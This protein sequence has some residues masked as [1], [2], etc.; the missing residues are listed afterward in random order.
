V[1][2]ATPGGNP[3]TVTFARL[4]TRSVARTAVRTRGARPPTAPL[5]RAPV[6]PR[7]P[8]P[9]E[10]TV[11]VEAPQAAPAPP[12]VAGRRRSSTPLLVVSAV[13]ASVQMSWS[14]VVPVL[15][16]YAGR[17]GLGPAELGLVVSVFGVGRLLVNVPAG[18]L[19]RRVDRRW[20]M[21]G[22]TAAVVVFQSLTGLVNGFGPLLVARLCTGLA[23]GVAITSGMTLL[24]D[25]ATP[26]NRG[27]DMA[28]LQGLQL[29]GGALGP[30]LGGFLAVAAGPRAAFLLSG[31]V[32]TGVLLWG[33]Q[34]LRRTPVPAPPRTG[35]AESRAGWLSRDLCG[36][37]LMGFAVFFHRFG[38]LQS[39]VPLI[40]YEQAGI[41][42]G[43]LGLLL[44]AVTLCNVLMVRFA[45]GLSDRVGRK[46]VIIPSSVCVVVGSAGLALGGWSVGFVVATLVTGVAAGFSGPTPAAYLVDVALPSA[47][48]VV[49][50]IYR[51]FGDLGG[52]VGPLLLGLLAETLGFGWAAISLAGVVAVM[53][54]AFGLLSREST[55]PHRVAGVVP[56]DAA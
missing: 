3:H 5:A 53:T 34:V 46:R 16:Y 17:F 22:A 54:L 48:S 7:S 33:V 23:G 55:G 39:L 42:V 9:L 31:V 49:T 10:D 4:R 45:G 1:I 51:T 40:A 24:A 13:V 28:T 19:A 25:L 47:R 12:P 29:A 11:D 35:R 20:L 32:A 56:T 26:A 43:Q 8:E 6:G 41:G 21:L 36:V 38:G 15:P 30:V 52:I 37:Y 50:G 2:A 27:R 14:L 44:S 18:L